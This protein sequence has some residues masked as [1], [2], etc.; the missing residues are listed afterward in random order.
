MHISNLLIFGSRWF[1]LISIS[2]EKFEFYE[3]KIYL[4]VEIVASSM[5]L[6]N[7][8]FNNFSEYCVRC[9]ALIPS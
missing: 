9:H 5:L 8:K 7:S 4:D 3:Y 1:C 6:H 2:S